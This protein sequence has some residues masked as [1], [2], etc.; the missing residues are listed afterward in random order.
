MKWQ[1]GD[2][3]DV[4]RDDVRD[5]IAVASKNIQLVNGDFRVLVTG[6]RKWSDKDTL[7]EALEACLDE[8]GARR[9]ALVVVHGTARCSSSS[10]VRPCNDHSADHLADRWAYFAARH[11]RRL[12]HVERHAADWRG[13]CDPV[14]CKPGHR[15]TTPHHT[16]WKGQFRSGY[17]T[18][19]AA[20]F[21]RNERMADAGA[22]LALAFVVSGAS[23]SRGTRHCVSECRR[24]GIHV[25]QFEA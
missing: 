15:R 6:S 12:V 18:C 8:A 21:Y 24:R 10:C 25:V 16:D 2:V 22:S 20:G 3:N 17:D 23:E 19:P 11:R 7:T 1:R 5:P 14:R 13:P 4:E 9:V